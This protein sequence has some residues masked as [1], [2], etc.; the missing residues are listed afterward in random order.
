MALAR[1]LK[2]NKIPRI[3]SK[4]KGQRNYKKLSLYGLIFLVAVFGLYGIFNLTKLAP[5]KEDKKEL[6]L[7]TGDKPLP[8]E[9]KLWINAPGGLNMRSEPN[10]KSEILKIIP[11][12]TEL[13][14]LE[15]SGDW[16]KISY[17]G[18]TGWVHKDYV[19][20]FKDDEAPEIAADWAN[21]KNATFGYGVSYPKDWVTKDY[22][23]NEAAKLLSYVGFGL[24]LSNTI[25]SD[26]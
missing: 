12:G 14:A 3:K 2:P 19:R 24:Q 13:V 22:G 26:R 5:A 1:N 21:Y 8:E 18:K 10:T 9:I 17:D 25:D 16:Y 23:A 4:I 7:D 15:L 6:V 20:T 11:D